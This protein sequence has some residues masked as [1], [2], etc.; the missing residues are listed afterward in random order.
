MA[1]ARKELGIGH[2]EQLGKERKQGAEQAERVREEVQ[3]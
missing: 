2:R 3:A 1:K